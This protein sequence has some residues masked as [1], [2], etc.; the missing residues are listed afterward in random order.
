M[1][2]AVAAIAQ[3]SESLAKVHN[4]GKPVTTWNP[5]QV[6]TQN[7]NRERPSHKESTHPKAPITVHTPPVRTGIRFAVFTAISLT[8]VFASGHLFSIS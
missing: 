2:I 3:A 5:R 6:A 4:S 8:V 1:L 7:V